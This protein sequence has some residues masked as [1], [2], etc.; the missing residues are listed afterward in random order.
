[1]KQNM[2]HALQPF[3]VLHNRSSRLFIQGIAAG[4]MLSFCSDSGDNR[5][6][7]DESVGDNKNS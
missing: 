2:K 1:M 6:D 5:N 4:G 3:L 7:F